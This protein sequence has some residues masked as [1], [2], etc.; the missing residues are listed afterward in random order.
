[1]IT[2]R[3]NTGMHDDTPH[4]HPKSVEGLDGS[5]TIAEIVP[6]LS[7]NAQ[8]VLGKQSI[9]DIGARY[10]QIIGLKPGSSSIRTVEMIEEMV[11]RLILGESMTSILVSPHMPAPRT[12]WGWCRDDPALDEEVKWATAMGQRLL[13]DVTTDIAAGGIFS[14]GDARRDEL[15]I[16]VIEKNASQRNRREFGDRVQVDHKSVVV[17]LP[18]WST[19]VS[20]KQDADEDDGEE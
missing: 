17:N 1:M 11:E 7:S 20:S 3:V 19:E 12:I 2:D 13:K 5:L 6:S 14:T 10:R 8:M 18:Q 4:K 9:K 15:L 16:K